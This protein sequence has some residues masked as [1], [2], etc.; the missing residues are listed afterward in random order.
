MIKPVY[1]SSASC[2]SP[3]QNYEADGFLDDVQQ[4]NDGALYIQD[5]NYRKYI[6]P[7]AIRRMSRLLKMGISTGMN[8]LEQAGVTKPNGIITGTG[9]GSMTDTEKFLLDMIELDEGALTPTSFIQSTYN[10]INGWLALQT[11]SNGYNQT[12]VNRGSSLELALLDAQMLLNEQQQQQNIL[13]G[14]FDEITPDYVKVKDK[15]G[16]WKRPAINNLEL[17]NNSNTNGSIAGEGAAFFCLTNNANSAIC[18]MEQIKIIQKENPQEVHTAIEEQLNSI[19]FSNLDVLLCGNSGDARFEQYYNTAKTKISAQTTVAA[20][21]HLCGEYDTSTGFA[22]WMATE[23]F[24]RQTLPEII[25]TQ[26]SNNSSI[27]NMLIVNH[28][29]LNSAS[30]ISLKIVD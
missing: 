23:I 5:P 7:V 28:Y 15:I 2:I 20:F 22:L 8:A 21:K 26:K 3:Q 27:K 17:L 9:R 13:V 19:D 1:I 14:C 29:T 24:K 10:S 4:N 12:Y 11:K 25:V 16:Y 30:I 6:N 18:S